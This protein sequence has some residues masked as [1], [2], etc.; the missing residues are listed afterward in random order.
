MKPTFAN[1]PASR[2]QN[3]NHYFEVGF[4]DQAV[5]DE[6]GKTQFLRHPNTET[7]VWCHLDRKNIPKKPQ[8]VFGC[9]GFDVK[10]SWGV[11]LTKTQMLNVW[12]I[13]DLFTFGLN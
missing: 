9:L 4:D 1:P 6:A 7:E 10:V 8:E 13:S 5:F 12:N 11:F 2:P 3:I